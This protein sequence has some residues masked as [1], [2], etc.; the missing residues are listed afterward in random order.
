LEVV[1]INV[2]ADGSSDGGTALHR[3]GTTLAEVVLNVDDDQGFG[4]Q[5]SS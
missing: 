3:Q 5:F 4:H 2:V 1:G